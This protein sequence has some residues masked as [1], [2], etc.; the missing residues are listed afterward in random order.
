[1]EN[2]KIIIDYLELRKLFNEK[3]KQTKQIIENGNPYLDNLAEGFTEADD[4]IRQL[5]TIDAVEVIHAKWENIQNGHGCCSNCHRMDDVDR[6]AT[7]CRYC[8]AKM[9]ASDK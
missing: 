8:G 3:Y 2:K 1:M 5:P 9:D 4:V 7:H 6:L